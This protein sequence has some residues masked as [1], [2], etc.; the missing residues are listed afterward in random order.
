MIGLM[1][2]GFFLIGII[3]WYSNGVFKLINDYFRSEYKSYL[4]AEIKKNKFLITTPSAVVEQP[5]VT[6]FT[7]PDDKVEKEVDVVVERRLE[8]SCIED[9]NNE[10]ESAVLNYWLNR[11]RNN[12]NRDSE[13]DDAHCQVEKCKDN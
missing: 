13:N 5:P 1:L 6:E 7:L 10:D 3:S 9:N 11:K 2:R 4:S 8:P 12:H